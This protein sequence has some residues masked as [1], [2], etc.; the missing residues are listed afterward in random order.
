[1]PD[2]TTVKLSAPPGATYWLA[3]P[4]GTAA[5]YWTDNARNTPAGTSVN[6][7]GVSLGG[8]LKK[9]RLFFFLNYG[10]FAPG[11]AYPAGSANEKYTALGFQIVF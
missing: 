2:T 8:P 6:Q 9:D 7:L 1:M 11:D 5:Q 3:V 4:S 10:D